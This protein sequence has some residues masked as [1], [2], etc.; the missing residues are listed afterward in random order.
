MD[1]KKLIEAKK[2]LQQK[3]KL[4]E[5]T[6]DKMEQGRMEELAGISEDDG[7]YTPGAA[8]EQVYDDILNKIT[9]MYP[10]KKE[11]AMAI[12]NSSDMGFGKLFNKA[13]ASME[14]IDA[15]NAAEYVMDKIGVNEAEE[16][17]GSSAANPVRKYNTPAESFIKAH[18]LEKYIGWAIQNAKDEQH[19]KN[20][21]NKKI[22]EVP[23][24]PVNIANMSAGRKEH[25]PKMVQDVIQYAIDRYNRN[26]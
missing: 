26:R 6:L 23:G 14:D 16:E 24:L 4:I 20:I 22:K 8:D 17:S 21:V 3:L 10:D 1:K 25:D 7:S 18:R 15:E 11:A 13:L 12:M 9:D 19:L 2:L 5:N